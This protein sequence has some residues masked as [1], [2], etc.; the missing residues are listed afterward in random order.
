ME[1]LSKL[2]RKNDKKELKSTI[3]TVFLSLLRVTCWSHVGLKI[4]GN[5]Y[6]RI[7]KSYSSKHPTKCPCDQVNCCHGY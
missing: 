4:D 1:F 6:W 5:I 7:I 3:L 2:L